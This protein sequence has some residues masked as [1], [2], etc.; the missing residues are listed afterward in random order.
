MIVQTSTVGF[1]SALLGKRLLCLSFSP[2][3]INTEY[4]FSQL[5]IAES[6]RSLDE[7]VPVLDR[8]RADVA[9]LGGFPPPGP[10]TPRVCDEIL[11]L[12]KR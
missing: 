12:M 5:G 11:G 4:D 2:R 1:E 3:V 6:V 10:A 7:L 9:D 8:P